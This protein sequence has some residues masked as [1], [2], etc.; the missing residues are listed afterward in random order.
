[1]RSSV[2]L[3]LSMVILPAVP[4]A[5][6]HAEDGL[7]TVRVVQQ[8]QAGDPITG[9]CYRASS[10]DDN[11]ERCDIDDGAT[12]GVVTLERVIPGV[13]TV[14]DYRP[15]AGYHAAEDFTVT[16]GADETVTR[17]RRHAPTPRLRIVT[18][19]AQNQPLAG[20]CWGLRV[21]GEREGYLDE[22]DAEDGAADGTT[23]FLDVGAGEYELFHIDAPDGIDRIDETAVTMRAEDTTLTFKLEPAIPPA[24]TVT[25]TVTGGHAVGDELLGDFGVWRGSSELEITDR[26]ERCNGDGTGCIAV[27]DYDPH[28]TITAEDAGKALRYHVTATNDGGTA[29]AASDLHAVSAA[30]APEMTE[31]PAISG[32]TRIGQTLTAQPGTWTHAPTFTYQWHRCDANGWC[33]TIPGATAAS[34][35]TGTADAEKRLKVTVK[36]SN[37]GGHATATSE[38]TVAIDD[39]PYNVGR[40][41]VSGTPRPGKTLVANGGSWVSHYDDL[42]LDYRWL[43][44]NAHDTCV[45]VGYGLG[46]TVQI[47]DED[48]TLLVEVTAHD[49]GGIGRARSNARAVESVRP[50]NTVRPSFQGRQR[51]GYKLTG[52]RGTWVSGDGTRIS[53]SP[54]WQRCDVDGTSCENIPG[55]DDLTYKIQW[56]DLGHH[57]RLQVSATNR[58]GTKYAYSVRTDRLERQPPVN[59]VKPAFDDLNMHL[60]WDLKVDTGEWAYDGLGRIRY[61]YTWQRCDHNGANCVFIEPNMAPQDWRHRL[62]EAD[63]HHR[64]RV[65]VTA[66][67]DEGPAEVFSELTPVFELQPPVNVTPPQITPPTASYVFDRIRVDKGE[68]ETYCCVVD[69]TVQWQRC[70]DQGEACTPILGETEWRYQFSLADLGHTIRALVTATNGDGTTRALSAPT[71]VVRRCC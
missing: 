52:D 65:M 55:A 38:L 47:D 26:W 9:G 43:R 24:N 21:P 60:G 23:T 62:E 17:A 10:D 36:A 59:V 28:Y 2:S 66:S 31:P 53:Y 12:D 56:A 57:L 33:A 48:A 44:C 69:Y 27:G 4:A 15:P 45:A 50:T 64:L 18:T 22:C 8:D 35:K 7:G 49:G 54:Q 68:W 67:S 42:T 61:S 5:A 1:M 41:T 29:T 71:P 30:E 25:P 34:Y 39:N 63:L 3:L 14:H 19:D 6:A 40:P 20:S 51:L 32:S 16:V 37:D 46:Y 13:F 58:S 70:D 11:R